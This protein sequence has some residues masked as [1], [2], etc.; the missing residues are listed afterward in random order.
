MLTVRTESGHILTTDRA[1]ALKLIEHGASQVGSDED[2]PQVEVAQDESEV[3][4][5]E[6][7]IMTAK[8]RGR[9]PK[10]SAD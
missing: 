1:R 5:T 3:E 9:T 6:A 7:P 8:R 10:V 4:T 2:Q